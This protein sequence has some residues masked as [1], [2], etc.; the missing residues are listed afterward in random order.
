[1]TEVNKELLEALKSALVY[2]RKN[3]NSTPEW[4]DLLDK[5]VY[6]IAL[7]KGEVK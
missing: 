6:A 3:P 1:M 7:A 2:V 4:N 5:C